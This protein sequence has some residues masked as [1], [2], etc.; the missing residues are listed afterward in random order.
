[1]NSLKTY[2]LAGCGVAAVL[3]APTAHAQ[4]A[5]T[6]T[7]G[8]ADIVITAQR[9]SE[10]LQDVPLAVSALD[11]E[12]IKEAGFKDVEDLTS[13]VPNL[14]ISALWGSSS[15]KIFMRG[16]GNNNFNQTA[17][18]KVAVY[19]DQVYLS[20]PS[21]QLFQMYDLERIEVLRGPQGT[22][23]G[24]NATGGA[25]SVYSKLPGRDTEGYVRAGY[26]NYDAYE[27]EGAA[28]LP[29]SDTLSARVAGT[30]S[31]RDGYVK[32]LGTGKTVNDA[33]QWA[34]RAILRW[35]PSDAVD[36]KLN[37]H[38]GS[39]DSTHN[40]SVHRG[41][42][43]P[44]QLALGNFVKMS[45]NDIIAGNAV[46]IL[47]YADPNPDPYVNTYEGD[48]F[49]K[50]DLVGVS[51]VSDFELGD[52]YTLTSVS[53]YEKSKRHVLQEGNGAPSTIFTI[54]WGPST[55]ESISQELRLSSPTDSSFS[56]LVG[57]FAFHEKGTVHN[58]YN[59]ASVS[60]ALGFDA[61]DQYYTQ[62]TD[63]FAAFAQ[64]SLALTDRLNLTL[65]GRINHEK[66]KLDH[67]TF[68][69]TAA[70]VSVFPGPLF[71]LQLS[72]SWTE[73]SGRAAIDY[74]IA[75]DVLL[76]ASV[77]RGFTSGGFN[78]G[79][80][81]DP[82]G[83]ER[84]F[85]PETVVSYEAG[86]KST[87]FDRR[88]RI[89]ATAFLYDYSDLQVFTFTAGGLQFIENASNATIKGI[90][91]EVQAMPVDNLELGASVG[92]LK[93]EYKDFVRETG[94]VTEDLSGN[95]LIGAPNSQFNIV[96]KYT[97]PTSK[98]DF[99]LRG[100]Y[101]Y[102]GHRY[103]DERE[104]RE[105]SSQGATENLNASI[106][107]TGMNDK[108]ELSFWVKNLTDEVTIIDVVEVGL[109]GYQNVWYNMPRTYGLSLEYRF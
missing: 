2:L 64:G 7:D 22:L 39:S 80:F 85:N 87:L 14:N 45:A 12:R 88:L 97:V 42:F 91:L 76:F 10:S 95:R 55:F 104:L 79:A 35:Q 4:Q 83:A 44:A 5:E 29:L 63:T 67:R 100:D 25:I 59:L 16:I 51:L 60:F 11:S 84:I 31:K 19:L 18:S 20:A 81:N 70:G 68:A 6:E 101:S 17:E 21:G 98:G 93:S 28:T 107:Y 50:V 89:N 34:A 27:L 66:R 1:M 71:D 90:E 33:E 3:G 32:D 9:R 40:N 108:F 77:N 94:G 69:T 62:K 24:K 99:W 54:D 65:G 74:E 82:V 75:D 57:A 46:D 37:V 43:D 78:T 41:I 73:W 105:L 92:L 8:I 72:E 13:T 56:W 49:A 61:F 86:I 103:Y 48:T 38:G 96:G 15:P 106:G 36:I 52:G 53:G 23:Y 26:G 47:G 102:S 109:F 58:F 30:W